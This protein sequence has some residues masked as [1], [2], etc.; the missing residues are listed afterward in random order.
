[1]S[2]LTPYFTDLQMREGLPPMTA[3]DVQA[4]QVVIDQLYA[5]KRVAEDNRKTNETNL[6]RQLDYQAQLVAL[7]TERD[8]LVILLRRALV[9]AEPGLRAQGIKYLRRKGLIGSQLRDGVEI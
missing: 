4:V 5:N 9:K 6:E 7:R 2:D 8:D 3:E 1:M